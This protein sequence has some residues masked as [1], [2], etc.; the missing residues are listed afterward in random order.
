[1]EGKQN[2]LLLIISLPV[3]R[4]PSRTHSVDPPSGVVHQRSD[5][6]PTHLSRSVFP[7]TPG[8]FG[9]WLG[10]RFPPTP[11]LHPH[12]SGK[13][14]ADDQGQDSVRRRSSV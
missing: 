5:L 1:M 12:N 6:P 3:A 2:P 10:L 4:F 9:I 11:S 14:R 13:G 7:E 8:V